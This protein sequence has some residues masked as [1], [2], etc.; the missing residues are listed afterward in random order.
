[1]NTRCRSL[2]SACG[3]RRTGSTG[4]SHQPPMGH[5]ATGMNSQMRIILI[6]LVDHMMNHM[7]SYAICNIFL[8]TVTRPF[9]SRFFLIFVSMMSQWVFKRI[10]SY[11]FM[12]INAFKYLFLLSLL[13]LFL[14]R[15]FCW[16][17]SFQF[18][19]LELSHPDVFAIWNPC[20]Q[21][22][23]IHR[24]H[25]SGDFWRLFFKISRDSVVSQGTSKETFASYKAIPAHFYQPQSFFGVPAIIFARFI[26]IWFC[27]K[28]WYP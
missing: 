18:S 10:F 25:F 11:H 23:I 3:G 13:A 2:F 16:R 27:L 22:N 15:L 17:I 9:W 7:I 20:R 21:I 19:H 1:M 6:D 8:R 5:W 14:Q 4:T 28:G 24:T 12:Y 26:N